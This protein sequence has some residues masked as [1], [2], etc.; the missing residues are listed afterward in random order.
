MTVTRRAVLRITLMA[1]VA[2]IA[3]AR[4]GVCAAPDLLYVY[5]GALPASR[6][7]L[8]N[9]TA[10]ADVSVERATRWTRLRKTAACGRVAGLTNWSDYVQARG[11]FEE[12]GKRLRFEARRGGLFYWEMV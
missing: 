12:R 8:G 3:A 7:W 10:F 1:G 5:D 6:K 4:A 11:V 2:A 9:R